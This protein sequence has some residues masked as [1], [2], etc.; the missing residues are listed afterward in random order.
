MRITPELKAE[1][2]HTFEKML[3]ACIEHG[4]GHTHGADYHYG[5][6]GGDK[7]ETC[8]WFFCVAFEGSSLAE[9]FRKQIAKDHAT[10]PHF[11]VRDDSGTEIHESSNRELMED[12][13]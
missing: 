7:I 12:D 3:D 13:S 4:K 2:M 8:K 10:H 9:V 1:M 5:A 6:G 11:R